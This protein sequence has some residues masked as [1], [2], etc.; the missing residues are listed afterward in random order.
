M[1]SPEI[2]RLWKLHQ[3]D[4]AIQEIRTRA[5]HLD[6]GQRIQQEIDQIQREDQEVGGQARKL[7]AEQTDLEL[8]NKTIDDKLKK[9]DKDLYGGKVVTSREVQNLE[10][11]IEI[12]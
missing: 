4:S 9:I 11:E 2:Q 6:V 3:I 1:A 5:A 8:A 7:H 12:L 10:K